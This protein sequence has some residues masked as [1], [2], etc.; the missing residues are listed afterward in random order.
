MRSRHILRV[1]AGARCGDGPHLTQGTRLFVGDQELTGVTRVELICEIN[2]V[3][4][5]RVECMADPPADLLSVASIAR[6]SLWRRFR[7]WCGLPDWLRG[8]R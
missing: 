2:D 8:V 4:R 7:R 1:E 3:W 5:A 6:P